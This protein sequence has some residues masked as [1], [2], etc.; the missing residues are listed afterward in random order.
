MNK[1][2]KRIDKKSGV[3]YIKDRNKI[4]IGSSVNCRQRLYNHLSDLKRGKHQ[5]QKM[6][7]HF[8][9]YGLDSI[10]IEI[11]EYCEKGILVE[12]EQYWIDYYE[13]YNE[14]N[15]NIHKIAGFPFKELTDEEIS[16]RRNLFGGKFGINVYKYSNEGEI[17]KVYESLSD[18]SR[19]NNMAPSCISS[20]INGKRFCKDFI[21]SKR[22]LSVEEILEYKNQRKLRLLKNNKAKIKNIR[23]SKT[24]KEYQHVTLYKHLV[25]PYN[26]ADYINKKAKIKI[27]SIFKYNIVDKKLTLNK[28]ILCS[29]Y[30]IFAP[31][32]QQ[33]IDW[34]REKYQ[35]LITI[36]S[37]SQESWQ[38]H[39][40]KPGDT[41]NNMWEEDYYS[42]YEA[43]NG[44]LLKAFELI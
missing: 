6:N 16:T 14:N 23:M 37:T 29:E 26:L 34:F 2:L 24:N 38:W 44:A 41:L 40:Q 19:D 43:L 15:F 33:L 20:Y 11:L 32:Y 31:I 30:E 9:K 4:Y 36:T 13:S 1:N 18:A 42:Y 10:K 12:R 5:N 25:I 3:Y 8:Q 17:I 28:N 7:N 21:F 39:I 35:L 27:E 22:V